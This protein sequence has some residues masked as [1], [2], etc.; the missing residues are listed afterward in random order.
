VK[1]FDLLQEMLIGLIKGILKD[2]NGNQSVQEIWVCQ[3]DPP[4]N[5][6]G[7]KPY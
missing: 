3:Y 6:V 7:Q 4:G 5:F 1:T 2:A